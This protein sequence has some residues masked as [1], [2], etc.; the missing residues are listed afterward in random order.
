[1]KQK[2]II[3]IISIIPAIVIAL[4]VTYLYKTNYANNNFFQFMHTV[5]DKNYFSYSEAQKEIRKSAQKSFICNIEKPIDS[6]NFLDLLL[7]FKKSGAK[8]I[9]IESNSA[10]ISK[11]NKIDEINNLFSENPELFIETLC[12]DN[13]KSLTSHNNDTNINSLFSMRNHFPLSFTAK[14]Q[15]EPNLL[16][17]KSVV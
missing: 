13:V 8:R 12:W 9:I 11:Y 17:R 6:E 1:M 14:N 4:S 15:P 10:L 5:S 16:D 2:N 7:Y 3:K